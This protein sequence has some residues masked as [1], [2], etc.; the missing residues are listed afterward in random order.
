MPPA[1]GQPAAIQGTEPGQGHLRGK[2]ALLVR[3]ESELESIVVAPQ[4]DVSIYLTR[5]LLTSFPFGILLLA[6]HRSLVHHQGPDADPAPPLVSA[7][8]VPLRYCFF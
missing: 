6:R 3:A 5:R 8:V 2:G 7:N 4:E 1:A